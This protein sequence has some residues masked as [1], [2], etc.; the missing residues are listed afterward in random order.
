[1]VYYSIVY[2]YCYGNLYDMSK[3]SCLFCNRLIKQY[4][5]IS[6]W[7]RYLQYP[8]AAGVSIYYQKIGNR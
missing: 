6:I 7:Y 1:M 2:W 8:A 3:L 5:Y 4:I